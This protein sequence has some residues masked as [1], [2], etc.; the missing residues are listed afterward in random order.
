MKSNKLNVL[1]GVLRWSGPLA[2]LTILPLMATGCNPNDIGVKTTSSIAAT[3]P[4]SAS[5]EPPVAANQESHE[6][7]TPIKDALTLLFAKEAQEKDSPFPKGTH[8]LSVEV[9]EKQAIVDVSK[10]FNGLLSR[11][12]STEGLAQ[13][14]MCRAL[15][16]FDSLK[17]MH[18]KVEGKEYD[19]QASDWSNIPLRV[20]EAQASGSVDR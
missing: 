16:Q 17:T 8:L 6:T 10:E 9:K 4:A 1:R 7:P 2:L 19:S 20:D 13:K 18:V 15:A 3:P 5:T 12:E 11:G 14:K